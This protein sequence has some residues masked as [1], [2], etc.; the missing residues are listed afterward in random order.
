MLGSATGL[1]A[2]DECN[3]QPS[4]QATAAKEDLH[5][6]FDIMCALMVH[7]FVPPGLC[8]IFVAKAKIRALL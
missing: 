3:L 7:A 8:S 5:Q 2:S 1:A 6:E 4:P